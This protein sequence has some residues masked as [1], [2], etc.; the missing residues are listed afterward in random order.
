MK[1]R[2]WATVL[3]GKDV[4]VKLGFKAG[5]TIIPPGEVGFVTGSEKKGGKWNAII[6]LRYQKAIGYGVSPHSQSF[7]KNRF[8]K[9]FRVVTAGP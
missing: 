3:E 9:H 6:M 4:S 7:T 5:D 2:N 8:R 1:S